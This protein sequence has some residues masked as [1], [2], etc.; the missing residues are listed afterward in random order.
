MMPENPLQYRFDCMDKSIAIMTDL[1]KITKH[2]VQKLFKINL[3]VLEFN[4]DEEMLKDSD[5]PA[6]LKKRINGE[7]G[8]L[9]NKESLK[10][11]SSISHSELR[12]VV[13]AHLS[14]KNNKIELVK[15][16]IFADS[17]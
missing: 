12:W 8:H 15:K 6:S 16:M 10:L 13:A 17:G 11:L 7:Y 9:D 14:E 4:H 2:V 5:Y 3:L 1:G